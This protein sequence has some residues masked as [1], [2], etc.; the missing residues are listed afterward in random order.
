MINKMFKKIISNT[1][2]FFQQKKPF[3][4]GK[5]FKWWALMDSN[6]RPDRYERPALTN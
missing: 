6:Q 4:K 2:K 5:G 1:T 3:P